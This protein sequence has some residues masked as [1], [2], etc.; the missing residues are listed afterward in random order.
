[1]STGLLWKRRLRRLLRANGRSLIVT[2]DQSLYTNVFPAI[3]D[4]PGVIAAMAEAGADAFLT[5]FGM[6]QAF[7]E[8]FRSAGVIMRLDGGPTEIPGGPGRFDLLYSVE[9]AL[10]LGADGVAVMF[11]PGFRYEDVTARNVATVAADCARWNVPLLVEVLPGGFEHPELHTPTN[12]RLAA[13]IAAELG[14]DLI[15]APYTGDVDSFREVTRNCYRPIVL[16]GGHMKRDAT[17]REPLERVKAGMEAG[18]AGIAIG[19]HIWTHANPP[20]M[21]KAL[22]KVIH[23]NASVDEATEAI[24]PAREDG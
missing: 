4:P 21:V 16:L 9:H 18:A 1:M 5:T 12:I 14:A 3:A 22:L 7:G 23:E 13:R 15:K 20:G 8:S 10:A 24:G 2:L 17:E 11:F 6:L 19:P